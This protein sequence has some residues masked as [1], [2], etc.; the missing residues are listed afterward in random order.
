MKL[1]AP[2]MTEMR[3]L[4]IQTKPILTYI[5]LEINSEDFDMMMN[6]IE[7]WKGKICPLLREPSTEPEVK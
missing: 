6:A 2:A 1:E 5:P 3:Y 7:L 4:I